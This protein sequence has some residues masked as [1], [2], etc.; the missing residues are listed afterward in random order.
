ME[1]KTVTE[2]N[3]IDESCIFCNLESRAV[4]IEND[5][6]VVIE[7]SFPVTKHHSLIIP[8]RHFKDYF[9][10][11]QTEQNAIHDLLKICRKLLSEK[12]T[13][14][15]GFNVGINIGHD[16]GQT[17]N[18]CHIHLIPRRNGDMENPKGG[19]RGVIPDKM[20]Y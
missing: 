11:Q 13:S 2:A 6:A 14:I 20:H 16:A 17:I 5:Y 9:D 8:K 1:E 12:D 7:D 19:V 15:T 3:E 4:F 18:H 10:I